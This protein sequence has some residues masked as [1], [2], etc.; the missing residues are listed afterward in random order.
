MTDFR[1]QST[2]TCYKTVF[3]FKVSYIG[4]IFID[5]IRIQINLYDSKFLSFSLPLAHYF[6]KGGNYTCLVNIT[7]FVDSYWMIYMLLCVL[8]AFIDFDL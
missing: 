2:L 7:V 6:S 3:I 1:F 4:N 8:S 5:L